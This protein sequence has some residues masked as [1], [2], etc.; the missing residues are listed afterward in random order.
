MAKRPPPEPIDHHY[1]IARLTKVF[2]ITCLISIPTLAWMTWQDYGRDWKHWQ[3]EFIRYDRLRTKA[4]LQAAAAKIDAAKEEQYLTQKREGIRELRHR[5]AAL[6]KAE[7]GAKRAEGRWYDADQ[8]NR[9]R[10]AE[11]DSARYFFETE[12]QKDPKSGSTD[13]ARSTY[14]KLRRLYEQS[15]VAVQTRQAEWDAAKAEIARLEKTKT[16]AEEALK[17]IDEEY[18]RYQAKLK[19]LHQNDAFYFVRNAPIADMLAP[20]LKV[21]QVQ[22]D[23]LFN[24]VNFLKSQRVDRCMT[25][26]YAAD[27]RGFEEKETYPQVLRTHPRLDLFVDSNS[28]H[29]YATFGCT[30]CHG[31]RDGSSLCAPALTLGDKL[32]LSGMADSG[33]P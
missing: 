12:Q 33:I 16:D 21:Q 25:C 1:D 24:D 31:G 10:K 18:D 4:A 17:K 2:A 23:G 7:S 19:T 28:P 13:K 27:K 15:Q 20:N 22:L 6:S 3:K 14:E 11:M 30:S 29:P 5:R 8:L 32:A 26:H 9:S